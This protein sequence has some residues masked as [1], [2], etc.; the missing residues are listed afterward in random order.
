[1]FELL[2]ISFRPYSD[3]LLN[4]INMKELFLN[5]KYTF[6]SETGDVEGFR[7]IQNVF[8]DIYATDVEADDEEE[9]LIGKL[10][11][12]TIL[13]TQAIDDRYDLAEI[14]DTDPDLFVISDKVFDGETE[15]PNSILQEEYPE[16]ML[17]LNICVLDRIVLL[18]EYRGYGISKRVVKDVLFQFRTSCGMF[19]IQ[20]FPLQF[21][22]ENCIGVDPWE[23]RSWYKDLEKN[24]KKAMKK[25]EAYCQSIGFKKIKG[26][27]GLLFHCSFYRNLE[28]E[29]VDMNEEIVIPNK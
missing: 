27:D 28:L 23:D 7:Y 1:M 6:G 22:G 16:C 12:K 9:V 3:N 29:K 4:D 17:N 15:E 24:E 13:M 20:P 18:P 21:E 19:V 14:L 11:L 25:L 26:I 8:V 10:K 5:F 2:L